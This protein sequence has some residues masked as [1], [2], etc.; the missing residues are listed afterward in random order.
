M[1]YTL[2]LDDGFSRHKRTGRG[3]WSA[4]KNYEVCKNTQKHLPII[5]K[6]A[7]TCFGLFKPTH[8]IDPE[9]IY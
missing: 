5:K 2:R 4:D 9:I 7:I 1:A 6:Q 8:F 3:S